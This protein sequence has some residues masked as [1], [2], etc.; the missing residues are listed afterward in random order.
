MSDDYVPVCIDC[1]VEYEGYFA[2]VSGFY[3]MKTPFRDT[4]ELAK[5]EA[6]LGAH[7]KH[8]IRIVWEQSP[9]RPD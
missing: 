2:S 1:N 6:W 5:F 4:A 7:E 9:L 3:A 8:D